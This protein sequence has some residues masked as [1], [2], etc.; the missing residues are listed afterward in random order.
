MKEL[1]KRTSDALQDQNKPLGLTKKHRIGFEFHQDHILNNPL[2]VLT[3]CTDFTSC[4]LTPPQIFFEDI[5]GIVQA[6]FQFK[7]LHLYFKADASKMHCEDV[8]S[9]AN[10]ASGW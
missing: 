1:D 3:E 4:T 6:F 9:S 7:R 8:A 10:S 2:Q 5:R